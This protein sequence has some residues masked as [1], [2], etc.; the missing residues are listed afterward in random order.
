ME[1][2]MT[3][4]RWL[5]LLLLCAP[6][7]SFA[8]TPFKSMVIFGDSM[9]DTGNTTHLLKSLRQEEN[10]AFIVAPFK[11]FVINKMTDYANDY[12]VPQIVLDTGIGFV[13]HFFDQELAPLLTN[14]IAKIKLVPILPGKPYWNA[15]FSNGPVWNEY[16][17]QMGSI[18]TEDEERYT[19]KAFG[20]SWATTYDRQLTVW[21]LIRHPLAL[22]K[23]IVVGKLIPPSLGL[24][25][26][27]YLLEHPK[28]NDESV[29]FVFS[30]MSDYV[31]VLQF[32]DNYNPAIMQR[33][34][35]NVVS[36]LGKS[37]Q[38]LAR[39]GAKH[40][41]VM[42]ISHLGDT[43]KF[44]NTLD[45]EVLNTASSQHNTRIQSQIE[46]WKKRFPE[47][48]F[49]FI[50][51]QNHLE[52]I[53]IHAEQNGFTHVK[54]A[55]IDVKYPMFDALT[56]SPFANNYVLQYAQTLNYKDEQFAAGTTNYHMCTTPEQYMY[57]DEIHLST[58]T[59]A[60]LAFEVCK[61]M[62]ENGY[63]LRCKSPDSP[64]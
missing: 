41:I 40:V 53:A 21:N 54:E 1:I 20:G 48:D 50:N 5:P 59:H 4:H 35:N 17:A 19:N 29:Y 33:Y 60:Y 57:W 13:T 9:S 16:L 37:V 10:P 8:A 34:V 46:V 45:K 56:Q 18:S 38:K 22:V 28:L 23:S 27:A 6:L 36:N 44:S 7:L 11:T 26:E 61:S 43:P 3:K 39:A 58:R 24:T 63:E 62:Q 32:E 12:Y 42:G 30:G 47:V 49:V 64:I 14:V 2:H 51:T 25:V 15:R 31:N 52:K 55:C